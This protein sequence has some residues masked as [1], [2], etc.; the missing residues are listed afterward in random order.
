VSD[1]CTLCGLEFDSPSMGGPGICPACDCGISIVETQ[2]RRELAEVRSDRQREHDSRVKFAGDADALSAE[3]D[4][5]QRGFNAAIATVQV[6]EARIAELEKLMGDT[7]SDFEVQA[8]IA[9]LT[10]E[11]AEAR[12]D[13]QRE[14]DLRVKITGD[15]EARIA[16]L[17]AAD[18]GGENWV[19]QSKY[20][21]L[22]ADLTAEREAHAQLQ[23][24]CFDGG[25]SQSVFDRVREL[26]TA[27]RDVLDECDIPCMRANEEI[28][29]A[30]GC[31]CPVCLGRA[32]LAPKAGP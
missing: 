18:F 8:R 16:E 21:A 31:P 26:E 20:D 15:A 14:H 9:E 28:S 4:H 13:R 19:R 27:L 25:G 30:E 10:A 7:R 2:L 29:V 1:T 24:R 12:S 23:S 5:L 6:H 3:R 22:E 11:L 32:A 17:E